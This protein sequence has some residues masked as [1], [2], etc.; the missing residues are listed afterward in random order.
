[1][2]SLI[3]RINRSILTALISSLVVLIT[4]TIPL[5]NAASTQEIEELTPFSE[6][7]LEQMLAPIALYP[8][9]LLTHILI[10]ATYPIELIQAERLHSKNTLLPTA[11]LMEKAEKKDWDPSVTALL[12]FPNVLEKLSSDLSWT[13]DLGDAFLQDE[14]KLL[15]SI[16][17][18]RAQA[19][20]ADS[21][22]E[23]E[24]M[25]VTRVNN[26]I[27][28]EPVQ[29]EIVYVPYYD[30]RTVYGNW[31]WY[32][33]PPV[34]WAPYPYYVGRPNGQFY[35]NSGVQISFNFFFSA[36]HWSN[37][38]VVVIDHHRSHHYRHR[39]RIVTSHGSQKWHH[40]PQ[41]RRGVAYRST[42]VKQRYNSH[43]PSVAHSKLLRHSERSSLA[44]NGLQSTKHYANQDKKLKHYNKQVSQHREQKFAN[45]LHNSHKPAKPSHKPERIS[46]KR[47]DSYRDQQR[48]I[49][50]HQQRDMK[51]HQPQ[52]NVHLPKSQQAQRSMH[53]QQRES[54]QQVR[55]Q[56]PRQVSQVRQSAQRSQQGSQQ[57]AQHRSQG[58]SKSRD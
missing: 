4:S 32:N 39:G 51:S 19:D 10:A 17:S 18:L 54:T 41:H 38:R 25:S 16:Q 28:I 53:K 31:H 56:Q 8:D 52:R 55:S 15:A 1:M 34:Y 3:L 48:D 43:R 23:M 42:H 57:R 29:K 36:F 2:K 33:Y 14:A 50:I 12:A 44:H 27:V 6:A 35:W 20:E 5:A 30:P 58:H 13:Q 11:Q 45:K 24:N 47:T 9:S 46:V 26:R 21:L 40:K 49:K 7:E 37:H 22:S